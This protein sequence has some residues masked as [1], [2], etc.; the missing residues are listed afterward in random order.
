MSVSNAS[1]S[2]LPAPQI[3]QR[4][5]TVLFGL[6]MGGFFGG[7]VWKMG[8][9]HL[10]G[11]LIK[12]AYSLLMD[13][14]FYTMAITV[15]AGAAGRLLS[16]FGF[17]SLLNL[18]FSRLMMPLYGLPGVSMLGAT[19]TF[20]SDNMSIVPFTHDPEFMKN[21]QPRQVPLLCNLG[22]SYG[23]GLFVITVLV[24]LG[25]GPE[26][27]V[28][29]V[30]ALL[31][32]IVSV[33]LMAIFVDRLAN[34]DW[35]PENQMQTGEATESGTLRDQRSAAL[36][37]RKSFF[38]RFLIA[39]LDGGKYGVEIGL[40]M[41]P[42]VLIICT[43]VMMLAKGMP[44]GGYDGGAY[45]GIG[46]IPV[47]GDLLRPILEPLFGFSSG[48]AVALPVTA[49]GSV[50]AAVSLAQDSIKHHLLSGNEIAVFA[51]FGILWSGFLSTHVAILDLLGF[52]RFMT[53]AIW[54]HLIAGLIAGVIANW[55][56]RGLM[57]LGWV[58]G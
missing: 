13:T 36:A 21:F 49:L 41:I 31:G 6:V 18:L 25:Y 35:T 28:G 10:M 56:Y 2:R 50:G 5:H 20:L 7:L 34:G 8:A 38:E 23:M 55:L 16:E 58:T 17:M 39:I 15:L 24:S 3:Q 45:Q 12:T 27:L 48:G 44:S 54:S 46:L 57:A 43:A 32:S 26:A 42:G 33:R 37:N 53:A 40:N 14:V 30:A 22:T 1:D 29:A 51:A 47:M 52:R 19:A 4:L 11:T 9:P